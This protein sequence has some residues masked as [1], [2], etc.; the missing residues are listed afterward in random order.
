MI[1]HVAYRPRVRGCRRA[2]RGLRACR[3]APT[4]RPTDRWPRPALPRPAASRTSWSM[5]AT[6]CSSRS[7][8]TELTPQS[9]ATLDKQA[10][11]LQQ[12][13]PATPSP[14]KATPTSAAPANTTSRSAPAAPRRCATISRRA[15]SSPTACAPISYGKERRSRS[16]TTSRAGRRTAAPS[17]CSTRHHKRP[18]LAS[19]P[20]GAPKGRRFCFGT[21]AK[22]LRRFPGAWLSAET[23]N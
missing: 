14:S 10:Q 5:S 15:A 11:W 9:R 8:S 3:P 12:L 4:S 13:Q 18:E 1:S 21:R 7:D 2:D 6:A 19:R 20:T 22:F 23:K 17:R 16:A